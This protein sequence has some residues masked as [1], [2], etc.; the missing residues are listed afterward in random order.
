MSR[1]LARAAW[2]GPLTALVLADSVAAQA[3][4]LPLQAA[5]LPTGIHLAASIGLPAGGAWPGEGTALGFSAGVASARLGLVATLVRFD[6]E[7]RQTDATTGAGILAVARLVGGTLDLPL[8]VDVF[9]GYGWFDRPA[10]CQDDCPAP[11]A[12]RGAW[13]IP[14][15]VGFTMNIATPVASLRPWLAP[16]VEL[17]REEGSDTRSDE[18]RVGASA[19]VDLRF[20]GGLGVRAAWDQVHDDDRT[21]GF[22]ILYRF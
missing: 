2:T 19:G 10:L 11:G 20:V 17:F 13:R 15:G 3:P 22:G 5:S 6:P 8:Q 1:L 12:G 4:G 18:A 7:R 9:A 14:L 21:I 16:R